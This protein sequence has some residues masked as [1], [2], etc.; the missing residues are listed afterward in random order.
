MGVPTPSIR[1]NH[2]EATIEVAEQIYGKGCANEFLYFFKSGDEKYLE[3]HGS[4]DSN[5]IARAKAS[6]T[7]NALTSANGLTTDIIVHP[8]WEITREKTFFG[9]ISDNVC[10]KVVGYRGVIKGFRTTD[11]RTDYGKSSGE[12]KS[13]GFFSF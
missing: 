13:K 1:S 11:D 8:V 2:S 6:A 7:H 3:V 12:E 9:L 10:A 5:A 4:D